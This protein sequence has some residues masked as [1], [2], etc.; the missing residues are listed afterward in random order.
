MTWGEPLALPAAARAF[1]NAY[2]TAHGAGLRVRR[3]DGARG[4]YEVAFEHGWP[5]GGAEVSA[6]RV[7]DDGVLL[8]VAIA[9]P[10]ASPDKAGFVAEVVAAL[11]GYER[12]AR[13]TAQELSER[14]EEINL[15]YTISEILASVLSMDDATQRILAHVADVL[16]ARRAALWTPESSGEALRLRAVVGTPPVRE[17]IPIGDADSVTAQVFREGEPVNLER[18]AEYQRSTP[19]DAATSREALLAVPVSYTPPEGETRR[20][21]AI[22]LVGHTGSERFTAGDARMLA[23]IASQVGAAIEAQR[24]VQQSLQRERLARDMELA[25]HLQAKLLPDSREFADLAEVA[26]RSVPAESIGGDLYQLFRLQDGRIGVM[27]GDVSSHG[28]G[29]ALIMALTMSALAVHARESSAPGKVLARVYETLRDELE[30]TEMYLTLFY[31]VIQ[32]DGSLVYANA[33]HPHAF[34]F[35][36]GGEPERL[37]AT[38]PPLGMADVEPAE[39]VTGW[40]RKDTLCLFTDGLSDA[41]PAVDGSSGEGAL[42]ARIGNGLAG[43]LSDIVAA[44]VSDTDGGLDGSPVD[45][46]TILLVRP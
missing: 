46:R 12:E 11:L 9:C 42:L 32:P 17:R 10:L 14:Y 24:L 18:G 37:A 2:G 44:V 41:Y 30:S 20:V 5:P 3:R 19:R 38:H 36:P 25:H 22:T 7:L 39:S 29:A 34:R 1:L 6:E 43:P 8:E 23:A 27:I 45:D 15:L 31:G 40:A 21:G 4:A 33:G 26:A 16:G 13:S 35:S 28:V